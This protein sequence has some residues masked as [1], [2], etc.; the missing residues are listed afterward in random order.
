MGF[1]GNNVFLC[2][3][4]DFELYSFAGIRHMSY[5]FD[6]R[7]VNMASSGSGTS[8]IMAVAGQTQFIKLK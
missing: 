7:I 4:N 5:T 8:F 6:E 2:G 1:A 3:E